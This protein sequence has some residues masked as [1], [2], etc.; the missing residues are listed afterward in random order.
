M[1][2]LFSG[3][4]RHTH[5]T[6]AHESRLTHPGFHASTGSIFFFNVAFVQ[7]EPR[8]ERPAKDD[9]DLNPDNNGFGTMKSHL[10][11]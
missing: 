11:G 2:Q 8:V 7:N 9:E 1:N 4:T 6:N 3:E 10:V 5:Q